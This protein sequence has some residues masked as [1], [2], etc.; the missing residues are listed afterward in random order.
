MV[1]L[2]VD[3]VMSDTVRVSPVTLEEYGAMDMEGRRAVWLEISDITEDEFESHMARERAREAKVP[4]VGMDAP[5]FVADVLGP[6][7]Q[8]SGEQVRLSNLR[9]K[10]V[11]I[12]FGS[13]T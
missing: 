5:D 8:R 3:Y 6:N 12:A 2:T 7:R 11:G 1:N 4:A 13:F 9:G 10:P